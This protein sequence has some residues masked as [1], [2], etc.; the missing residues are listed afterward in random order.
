MYTAAREIEARLTSLQEKM[1]ATGLGAAILVQNTDLYYFTGS[2][3][4]GHLVVPAR[5]EPV[6]LVCKSLERARLESL[7]GSIRQQHAFADVAAVLKEVAPGAKTV[8]LELDMK[9]ASAVTEN[10]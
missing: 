7:L 2:C 9:T 1:A 3:Q 8:G 6:Y 4:A 5:G 10:R